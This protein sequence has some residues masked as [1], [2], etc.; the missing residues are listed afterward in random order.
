MKNL[1]FISLLFSLFSCASH[2]KFAT[3]KKM[4]HISPAP[5]LVHYSLEHS[6]ELNLTKEQKKFVKDLEEELHPNGMKFAKGII[7]GEKQIKVDSFNKKPMANILKSYQEIENNRRMLTTV[8]V[9]AAYKLKAYL[10]KEKWNQLTLNYK[11]RYAVDFQTQKMQLMKHVNPLPNYISII[12]KKENLNLNQTQE[13][14]LAAWQKKNNSRM[15][16]YADQVIKKENLL[17]QAV[18]SGKSKKEVLN[19]LEDSLKVRRKIATQKTTC[20]EYVSKVLT[21]EQWEILK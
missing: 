7:K 1:I 21:E 16:K 17:T 18:F 13:Q 12:K 20:R 6:D 4:R 14:K 19:L 9:E 8:K 3:K 10:S 5:H 2:H 15:W 11:K